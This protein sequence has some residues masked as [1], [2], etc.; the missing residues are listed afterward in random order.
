MTQFDKE[1]LYVVCDGHG[2]FGHW[3]AFRVAQSL[4][5]AYEKSLAKEDA[6]AQAFRDAALDLATYA[7][8]WLLDFSASGC[9]CSV[10][11][12][13]GPN[14]QIAWLGDSR[15]LAANVTDRSQRVDFVTPAHNTEDVRELQRVRNTGAKLLQVPPSSGHVRI[16]TPGERTPGLYT[17][18]SLG[19]STGEALG[20][21]QKPE[22][23][24]MSFSR[25]SGLIVLGSGGLWEMLDNRSGPGLEALHLLREG[26]LRECGPS[27]AAGTL[28]EEVQLR[29]QQAAGGCCDDVSCIV[30]HWAEAP[31]SPVPRISAEEA[32]GPAVWQTGGSHTSLPLAA[33]RHPGAG[34]QAEPTP[35][36]PGKDPKEDIPECGTPPPKER[37]PCLACGTSNRPAARFCRRCGQRLA[38]EAAPRGAKAKAASAAERYAMAASKPV[39]RMVTPQFAPVDP[40]LGSTSTSHDAK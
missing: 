37:L 12:R 38:E 14:V 17:T 35:P 19:D 23:R 11:L 10:I 9:T 33:L 8:A 25:T 21:L 7:D 39:E 1:V 20:I 15:A 36:A 16:F 40:A 32:A 31:G 2:P 18:R 4:P 26:R 29:W 6:L 13:Q 30:L 28:T 27:V 34:I 5:Y 22:F 3:V 24:K